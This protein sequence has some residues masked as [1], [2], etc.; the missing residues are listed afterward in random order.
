MQE[1]ESI[2]V[3]R[4]ELKIP[5]LWVTVQRCSASLVML[6]SHPGDRIFSSHLTAIK[7][8]IM[9]IGYILVYLSGEVSTEQECY[10]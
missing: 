5:S 7:D 3:V 10:D 1:R 9:I 2:M 6:N 4:C 8:Y